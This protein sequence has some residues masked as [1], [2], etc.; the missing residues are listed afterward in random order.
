MVH[1]KIQ[2]AGIFP[3]WGSLFE[4]SFWGGE[5]KYSNPRWGALLLGSPSPNAWN[6]LS[7]GIKSLS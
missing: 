6:L 4:G 5:S 1:L 2:N 7:R 3:C